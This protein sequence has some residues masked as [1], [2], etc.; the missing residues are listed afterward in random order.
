MLRG[1]RLPGL[2]PTVPAWAVARPR[3][4]RAI[5]A[6]SV[7]LVVLRAGAGY[8]KTML[9]AQWAAAHSGVLWCDLSAA[10]PATELRTALEHCAATASSLVIDNYVPGRSD[11]DEVVGRFAVGVGAGRRLLLLTRGSPP[12]RLE[13]RRL[14]DSVVEL[15]CDELALTAAESATLLPNLGVEADDTRIG[16]LMERT[17]G[18]PAAVRLAAET[19]SSPGGGDDPAAF[20]G[21]TPTVADYL[22]DEVWRDLTDGEREFVLTTSVLGELRGGWCDAVMGRGGSAR[23]LRTLSHTGSWLLPPRRPG[24]GYV[25]HPLV[26]E[27]AL[28]RLAE[29]AQRRHELELRAARVMVDEGRHLEAAEHGVNAEE[30]ELACLCLRKC[31]DR[32]FREGHRQRLQRCLDRFPRVHADRSELLRISGYLAWASGDLEL[33]LAEAHRA[34]DTPDPDL[35]ADAFALVAAVHYARGDMA[36]ER[37][38]LLAALASGA[39]DREILGKLWFALASLDYRCGALEDAG[40][41]L[42]QAAAHIRDGEAVHVAILGLVPLLPLAKG[43]PLAAVDGLVRAVEGNRVS[44]NRRGEAHAAYHLAIALGQAGMHQRALETLGAAQALAQDLD[45]AH[46]SALIARETADAARDVNATDVKARYRKAIAQLESIDAKAGLLHAWH[47]LAVHHRR[48]GDVAAARRAAHRSLTWSQSGDEAFV[49]LVGTHLAL[50]E[51]QAQEARRLLAVVLA[52]PQRYYHALA[53]LYAGSVDHADAASHAETAFAIIQDDGFEHLLHTEAELVAGLLGRSGSP[54][55]G[56]TGS[57]GGGVLPS[58]DLRLFG[59]PA[60]T[61]AAGDRIALRPQALE[62]LAFLALRRGA[63]VESSRICDALWPESSRDMRRNLQTLVW[64]LRRAIGE[65][66]VV[67]RSRGYSFDPEGSVQVD[68]ESFSAYLRA[69][70]LEAALDLYRGELLPDATWSALERRHMEQRYL[71]ALEDL[72]ASRLEQGSTRE[73]IGLLE[74]IITIDPLAEG[75]YRKIIA[76]HESIGEHDAARRWR[77]ELREVME[78]ELGV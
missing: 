19:L 40:V 18:W 57:S 38:S 39:S 59:G 50:L 21:A 14:E 49:A 5:D 61:G 24:E 62:L 32:A 60:I 67:T 25:Y 74:S 34:L 56:S 78:T 44:G 70:E 11:L 20:T 75:S 68:V 58:F 28:A 73:A 23:I 3:L 69:G 8:G 33:A 13:R 66:V 22:E 47:G 35:K 45:L 71:R 31:A 7:G 26:R 53:L 37:E 17:L 2:A 27:F 9:A 55:G 64:L 12:I 10:T 42:H 6:A 46:L 30:W 16:W 29:D 43:R 77:N 54:R 65:K 1:Q 41:A 76:G 63:T 4:L 48:Q 15:G 51:G 52:S 72:A 36:S